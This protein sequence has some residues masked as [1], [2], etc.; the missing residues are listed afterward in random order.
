ML[1]ARLET[2][3]GNY[4]SQNARYDWQTFNHFA[5]MSEENYGITI[6]NL[7]C[8]FFKLG[9]SSVYSLDENSTQLSALAGG[10]VD[11]KLEDGG[12]LGFPNQNGETSF[13][14]HFAITTHQSGFDAA[15]S[16]ESLQHQ[17][18]LVTG[19]V[20]GDKSASNQN[21]FSLLSF[22]DPNVLLLERKTIRRRN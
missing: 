18:P 2:N 17:N 21:Q 9:Q 4:A 15:R 7:D 6:S 1:T 8:S 11:K 20:S 22:S 10:R 16:I 14:Y 19:E 5:D 13:H 3:E 12:Y